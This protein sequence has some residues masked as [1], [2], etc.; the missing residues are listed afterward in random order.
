MDEELSLAG[1]EDNTVPSVTSRQGESGLPKSQAKPGDPAWDLE[2]VKVGAR[3]GVVPGSW[4]G[5]GLQATV[6]RGAA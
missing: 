1:P 3:L 6:E 4:V 5:R 2:E